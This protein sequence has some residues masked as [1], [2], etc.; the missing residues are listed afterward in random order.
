MHL[1]TIKYI[2]KTRSVKN[3]REILYL[4]VAGTRGISGRNDALVLAAQVFSSGF[5][6]EDPGRHL[7]SS[8]ARTGSGNSVFAF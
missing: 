7:R 5:A 2:L 8:R 3:P 4:T 6:V 1:E